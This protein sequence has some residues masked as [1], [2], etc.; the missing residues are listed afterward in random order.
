MTVELDDDVKAR[1]DKLSRERGVRFKDVVN[2]MM[3]LGLR[4]IAAEAKSQKR[5]RTKIARKRTDTR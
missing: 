1:L 2:D 3:R 5:A 4:D